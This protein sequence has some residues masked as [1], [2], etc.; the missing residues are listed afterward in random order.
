LLFF[1]MRCRVVDAVAGY[2]PGSNTGAAD[3]GRP[4]TRP[5]GFN[6]WFETKFK[7]QLAFSPI[8]QHSSARVRELD[9]MS[10]AGQDK[11]LAWQRASTARCANRST[12]PG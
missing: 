2:T 10:I 3:A 5:R 9:D 8:Q 12:T 11:L 4:L 1:L 7:E 6:A